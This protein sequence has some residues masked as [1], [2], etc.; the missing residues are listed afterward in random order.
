MVTRGRLRKY[1]VAVSKRAST[2]AGLA[3]AFCTSA[4]SLE[5]TAAGAIASN[6]LEDWAEIPRCGWVAATRAA[7]P[8]Q[9]G[10]AESW[11]N[12]ASASISSA[13]TRGMR[14]AWRRHGAVLA[15]DGSAGATLV[16]APAGAG[17]AAD[18]G[19]LETL[20]A[21]SA[22]A[23]GC[24]HQLVNASLTS[25]SVASG[26][27]GVTAASLDGVKSRKPAE[28]FRRPNF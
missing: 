13:R 25:D 3:P 24:A 21:A 15:S 23:G 27:D 14:A 6:S 9:I 16:E 20:T 11:R 12:R 18:T 28:E 22:S 2:L 26:T 19:A 1:S 8:P 7:A 4:S 5:S 17:A 10:Q